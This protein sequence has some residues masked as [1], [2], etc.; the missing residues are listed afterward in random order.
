MIQKEVELSELTEVAAICAEHGVWLVQDRRTMR[1]YVKKH[2]S[3]YHIEVYRRLQAEPI[4]NTPRIYAMAEEDGVLTVIEEYIPGETLEELLERGPLPEGKVLDCT[5]ALCRIVEAFHSGPEPI[6]NRD[7]KPSNIKITPDGVVKLVDL[8]AAKPCREEQ[9]RDTVLLGTQGYAAPEQYGFGASGIRTDIYSLGVLM[10]VMLTGHFPA[11]RLTEGRLKHIVAKC[12]ELSP[13]GRFQSV[14]ELR[15]ALMKLRHG[16][17]EPE[18][19]P[20]N[21]VLPG[22]RSRNPLKWLLAAFG[23]GVV[24]LLGLSLTVEDATPRILWINRVGFT[25]AGLLSILFSGNYRNVQRFFKCDRIR[26]KAARI[27][28][29]ALI[30]FGIFF[31]A[32]LAVVILEGLLA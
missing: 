23:Y 30:D 26:N 16:V 20:R 25:A 27:L 9:S 10:N 13:K 29:I 18:G 22:F 3:V 2:L 6:V 5:I 14:R 11:V 24:I 15:E 7:I 21:N 28:W 4:P 1:L 12:T 31:M 17:P 32:A 19:D 8:N